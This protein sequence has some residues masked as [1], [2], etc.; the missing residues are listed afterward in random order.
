V[1]VIL[2]FTKF[3]SQEAIAFKKLIQQYSAEEALDRAAQQ[4]RDD[5]DQTYLSGFKN[6]R[7]APT[8][9]S[10]L[11]GMSLSCLSL[12]DTDNIV[13]GQDMDKEG[14]ECSEIIELTTNALEKD[15]LKWLFVTVQQSNLRFR[16]W[17]MF[18]RYI[19]YKCVYMM[20]NHVF[21]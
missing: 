4:A 14:A 11:K 8:E 12:L 19:V 7:F 17:Q 1:P 13:H 21:Q 3:E 18:Q 5:F 6:R 10:Y 16:I 2:I 9:I 15:A 20:V